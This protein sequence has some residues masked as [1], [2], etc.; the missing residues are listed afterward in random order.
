MSDSVYLQMDAEKLHVEELK[1]Y[2]AYNYQDKD[3]P[4]TV[5]LKDIQRLWK[6]CHGNPPNLKFPEAESYS[7][8]SDEMSTVEMRYLEYGK[9]INSNSELPD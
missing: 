7:L 8:V 1:K 9:I 6:Y 3:K 5:V 4:A 2:R